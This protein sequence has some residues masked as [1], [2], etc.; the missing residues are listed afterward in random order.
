MYIQVSLSDY[1]VLE[2]TDGNSQITVADGGTAQYI[3]PSTAG[4]EGQVLKAS[5]TPATLEWGSAGSSESSSL[6]STTA[7]AG[8][9][10]ATVDITGFWTSSNREM[11]I[12]M[13]TTVHSHSQSINRSMKDAYKGHS[14]EFLKWDSNY[15]TCLF[16]ADGNTLNF[17]SS[18]VNGE[19]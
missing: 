19:W 5:S 4:S 14:L 13:H 7:A 9:G 3:I 2:S 1:S 16:F 6:I 10:S 11:V 12:I 15:V 18:A 8:D 17:H